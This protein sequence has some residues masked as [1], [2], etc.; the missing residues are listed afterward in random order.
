MRSTRTTNQDSSDPRQAVR[1]N[2]SE[3]SVCDRAGCEIVSG[4]QLD[5]QI[6]PAAHQHVRC[7]LFGVTV[8]NALGKEYSLRFIR[9]TQRSTRREGGGDTIQFTLPATSI[10]SAGHVRFPSR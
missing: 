10:F 8:L 9:P 1:S 3:R 5:V 7:G 4:Y 2:R 6:F